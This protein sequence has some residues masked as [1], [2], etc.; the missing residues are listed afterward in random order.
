MAFNITL[1]YRAS[2]LIGCEGK[3]NAARHEH[4]VSIPSVTE[5]ERLA[6]GIVVTIEYVLS[7]DCNESDSS[8]VTA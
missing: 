8:A 7:G 1:A 4:D 6:T 5:L 2:R 3:N